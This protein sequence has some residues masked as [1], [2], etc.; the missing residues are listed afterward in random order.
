MDTEGIEKTLDEHRW[1]PISRN[2]FSQRYTHGH[3]GLQFVRVALLA[4]S[5]CSTHVPARELY[6]DEETISHLKQLSLE[7]LANIQV[8]SVGKKAEK[9]AEAPA[10]I[11][12]I[13]GEELRRSGATTIPDA[14]RLVPGMQVARVDG[15]NW[16][17]SARGFND[18]F[19]N[20]LLVLIDGR[21]VYTPLFS[22][23]FW[24]TQDVLME[25]IDQIEVIRGPGASLW[26]ANAVNG[27]INIKTKSAKETQGGFA[28]G[29]VGTEER[30]FSSFRYGGKLTDNGFFRIYGK[31][32]DR[33][34]SVLPFGGKAEDAWNM[35]RGGFRMDFETSE[36]NLLTLQGDAYGGDLDQTF[37]LV[38][39]VPP[40]YMNPARTSIDV[41]GGN[42]LGRWTHTLAQD[43]NLRLQMYYDRTIRR[44]SHF[45]E[46]HDIYNVDFQHRFPVG[47]RQDIVWG[48]EYR[49][50]LDENP[51]G[52]NLSF[53]PV[54]RGVQVWSAFIQDEIQFANDRL[55]LTLGSKFEHND[56]TGFEVQPG[57]RL[58][59]TPNDRHSVWLSVARAVRT[60]SR[61]EDGVITNTQ[62]LPGA[63]PGFPPTAITFLGNSD[64]NSE[65]LTAYEIGYRIRPITHLSL[66]IAAFYNDYDQLR[67]LE[68][69]TLDF[70]FVPAYLRVP[71]SA[72]NNLAGETYGVEFA[73][74]AEL[75]DWWH[76]RTSYSYL[77]AQLHTAP[78]SFDTMSETAE[79]SSPHH[80]VSFYSLMNLSHNIEVDAMAR[81]VDSLSSLGIPS[82]L[83]LDLHLGWRPRERWEFAIVGQNLL[84][85]RRTEFG[86]SS[87]IGTAV[88]EIQRS[89][90]GRVTFRF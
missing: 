23:V 3:S 39:L 57:S 67:S 63:A 64:F 77:Q 79:G 70:A 58:L 40:T 2:R 75:A 48:T 15:H 66:D 20:K 10:A 14:F 65:E 56:F 47:D 78:G 6:P 89:V 7:D 46:T 13:T 18:L 41:Y 24:D 49:A 68:T 80:Q 9:L 60:P 81:Y 33:D 88:T 42:V 62:I 90:Y 72:G 29:G 4:F 21:S 19:A 50:V 8:T 53:D 31:Y 36:K 74:D 32:F 61:A 55:R 45:E 16:A 52:F 26:G 34:E 27:V 43:S 44:A 17:V 51:G 73:A 71:I 37:N 22:G 1:K 12:V 84:D 86:S 85:S 87:F 82:Y 69:G 83:S 35:A 5:L 59:W 38:T 76:L 28:T 25:D 30:G 54:G 11:Y